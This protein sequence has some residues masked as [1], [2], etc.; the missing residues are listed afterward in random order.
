MRIHSPFLLTCGAALLIGLHA[1]KATAQQTPDT[2]IRHAYT[3][4]MG[5]NLFVLGKVWGFLKYYHPAVAAGKYDWDS[6]LIRLLPEYCK[7]R[8]K[9]ERDALLEKWVEDL[10]PV[11]VCAKCNDSLLKSAWLKPDF[12]WINGHNFPPALMTRLLYIRDNRRVD[13]PYH[14]IQVY[15]DGHSNF[16]LPQHEATYTNLVYPSDP[17]ALLSLFRFWNAVEYWYP[18]KYSLSVPWDGVLRQFIPV[19]LTHRN[20]VDYTLD[21]QA[22][23]AFLHD[24]HGFFLSGTDT[25]TGKYYM[26]IIL[27]LVEGRAF[28][29]GITMKTLAE[30]AGIR[31][32]DLVEAVDGEKIADLVA[33]LTP[34]CPSSTQGSLYSKLSKELVRSHNLVS[35]VRILRNG[36]SL[37]LTVTNFSPLLPPDLYRAY[38]AYPKDTAFCLIRD[39]MG[40]INIGK[41]K[42]KDSLALKTLVGRTTSLIIDLRQNQDEVFGTGGG[43]IVGRLILPPGRPF[44]KMAYPQ[45]SY[46]GVFTMGAPA[47]NDVSAPTAADCY[48]GRIVLLV[49]QE[50]M[51]VGE[52][53][54]MAFSGAPGAKVLGTPTA[55]AD[56]A[57]FGLTVPGN[58]SFWFT[59]LGVYYPDG[60]ETQRIGIQ[61]DILVKQTLNGYQSGTDEQLEAAVQYLSR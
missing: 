4:T 48:H 2:S 20:V 57:V 58:I 34:Y 18:Y 14:F 1:G 6:V 12:S 38:F 49:N 11:P 25:V 7:V 27:N 10:G 45:P 41:F 31:V 56:G 28:V 26:P 40:Y 61:P 23:V 13:T 60:R 39:G 33:R 42:R 50:T 47:D 17:Y 43:D 55:G 53:L 30:K 16:L 9:K 15:T 51:S 19:M 5:E 22:M 21:V 54:A 32:G 37:D 44:V 46:P 52:F 59:G 36:V 29:T 24:S 8:T 3:K 35:R